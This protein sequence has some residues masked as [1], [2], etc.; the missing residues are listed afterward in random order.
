VL[1]K[2]K[3]RLCDDASQAWRWLSVQMHVV[4]SL[5][6]MVFVMVPSMPAEL[7]ALLPTGV[8]AMLVA[9]WFGAGL[10]ARLYK[11]KTPDARRP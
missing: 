6:L 2:I 11:Q 3:D 4:A 7:Q 5:A 9:L 1:E 10:W 8:K